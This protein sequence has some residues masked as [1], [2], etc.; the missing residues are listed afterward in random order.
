MLMDEPTNHLDA[1]SVA[2]L[3]N[4]LSRFRGTVFAITHD[5]NFLDNVAGWILEVDRGK[6]YPH[7]GVVLVCVCVFVCLCV[8]CVCASV[9]VCVCVCGVWGVYVSE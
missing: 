1:G 5:R 4:F 2:W 7:R 9:C 8:L 6:L 3:E